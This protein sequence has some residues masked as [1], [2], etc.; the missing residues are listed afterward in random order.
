MHVIADRAQIAVAAAIHHERFVT[1]AEQVAEEFVPP[2][3]ARGVSA[4][5][6]LH[7]GNE[8]GAR[9]LHDEMKVIGHEAERVHLPIRL[10][11][12]LAQRLDETLPVGVVFEDR[13]AAIAPIHDVI[14]R[15]GIL[16]SK[17]ARHE[18]ER[19]E[20]RQN[21]QLSGLTPL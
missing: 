21:C 4:Q 9:R 15:A 14:D 16:H 20:L 12:R 11:A 7:P 18:V 2:V 19:G 13:F 17:F 1:A 10:G 6:P 8:I 3:E 5:E